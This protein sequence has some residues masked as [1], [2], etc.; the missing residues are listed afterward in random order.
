MNDQ[1]KVQLIN[2]KTAEILHILK[3]YETDK[4]TEIRIMICTILNHI[5]MNSFG[6]NRLETAKLV[7]ES[8]VHATEHNL[9]LKETEKYDESSPDKNS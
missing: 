1:E 2:A 3:S 9:K 8:I 5:W 4:E 7:A 6:M